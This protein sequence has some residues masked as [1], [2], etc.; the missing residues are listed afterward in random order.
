MH[1]WLLEQY[2]IVLRAVLRGSTGKLF[3]I[4]VFPGE[5]FSSRMHLGNLLIF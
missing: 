3:F 4:F 2:H 1:E 5:L